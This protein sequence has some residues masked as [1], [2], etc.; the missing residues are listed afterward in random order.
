MKKVELKTT[1]IDINE[2]GDKLTYQELIETT[3]NV[4]PE[5][6]YS[7][8][9]IKDRARIEKAITA[10]VEKAE[11][12]KAKTKPTPVLELEDADMQ[13]LKK[14]VK[15]TKWMIR[16]DDLIEFIEYIGNI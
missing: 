3:L 6:G 1:D 13:N 11:K 7:F 4:R 15:D 2:E 16:H 5:G 8:K 12:S 14:Y 9:D 10:A